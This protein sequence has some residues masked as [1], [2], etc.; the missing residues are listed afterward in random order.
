MTARALAR[1]IALC[2]WAFAAVGLFLPFLFYTPL[3]A[4]YRETLVRWAWN[5]S[6]VA[7]ADWNGSAVAPADADLAGLMLGITGGSIAGKWIVHALVARGPLAEGRAWA[8]DLTLRGLAVWFFADSIASLAVGAAFNVWMINLVP[9]A[10]VGAPLVLSWSRFDAGADEPA[11]LHG[12]ARVCFWASLFGAFTGIAIAFGG[13]TPLLAPWFAGLESAHY[14]GAALGESPRRFALAFFGP[15]G[16]CTLAQ[17]VM[18]AML[19]RHEPARLRTALA[20]SASIVSWF[21][22]DSGYGAAHRGWFNIAM[23]NLPAIVATLPPWL[24]LLARNRSSAGRA[25]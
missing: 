21:V 17:F 11:P 8:R 6:A 5:G 15:I 4:P 25:S 24:V 1:W 16:G 14:G 18:L 19:V 12:V 9:L 2:S 20:G 23:V 10:L 22:V 7:P 3:L 13:S